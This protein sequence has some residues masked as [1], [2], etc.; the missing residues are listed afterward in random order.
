VNIFSAQDTNYGI[1]VRDPNFF[2]TG[3][4]SAG[5]LLRKECMT[6]TFSAKKERQRKTQPAGNAE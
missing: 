5:A 3:P 4:A 2:L 1:F 6:V